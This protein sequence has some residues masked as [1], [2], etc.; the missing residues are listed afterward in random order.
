VKTLYEQAD[1]GPDLRTTLNLAPIVGSAASA[2]SLIA[3]PPIAARCPSRYV[4][5]H[6]A[7]SSALGRS[8]PTITLNEYLHEWPDALDR[9]RS[10]VDGALGSSETAAT[11][12]GSRA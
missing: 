12:A 9:T 5:R 8:T 10:L 6:D 4:A 2:A 3:L 11:S 7:G 1:T